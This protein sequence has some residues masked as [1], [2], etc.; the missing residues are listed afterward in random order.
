MEIWV[1][2]HAT[3]QANIE[4]RFQGRLEFPLNEQGRREAVQ[5]AERLQKIEFADIYSSPLS[6]AT[7]TAEIIARGRRES[8][9]CLPLIQEYCWGA[10]EGF[11]RQEIEERY[12]GL[13]SMY[14]DR[15]HTSVPGMESPRRFVSRIKAAGRFICSRRFL[16]DRLL[17]ISHGRFINGFLMYMAGLNLENRWVF[18]PQPASVSVLESSPAGDRF[19]LKLFNDRC[20]LKRPP[21]IEQGKNPRA[22]I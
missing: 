4:G 2:R 19:M 18:S 12:P 5:L 11:T 17:L 21:H 22:F 6:R 7:E 13:F 15:W 9:S 20:H 3:T 14:K 1:V 8:T 16:E 10:I